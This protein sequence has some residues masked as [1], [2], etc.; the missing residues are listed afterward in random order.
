MAGCSN[1]T[2]SL[3]LS[4]VWGRGRGVCVCVHMCVCVHV[5]MHNIN[6]IVIFYYHITFLTLIP[7]HWEVPGIQASPTPCL[8]HKQCL[9]M[10]VSFLS[11]QSRLLSCMLF[12]STLNSS[13]RNSK[14]LCFILIPCSHV[15][16]KYSTSF[17]TMELA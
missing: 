12:Q 14:A 8:V 10:F 1:K 16:A 15:R 6:M 2:L 5:C 9:M 3:S 4:C 17:V 13:R 7:G 11:L